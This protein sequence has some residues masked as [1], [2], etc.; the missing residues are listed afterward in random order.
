MYEEIDGVYIAP[1]K[2][3]NLSETKEESLKPINLSNHKTTE[4]LNQKAIEDA[5]RKVVALKNSSE[6]NIIGCIYKDPDL[7][8][9]LK[10]GYNRNNDIDTDGYFSNQSW[11]VYYQIAFDLYTKRNQT[12]F[13]QDNI[14]FYLE[15]HENLA[16]VY[17]NS[18]GYK[19]I[20]RLK[21]LVHLRDFDGYLSTLKKWYAVLKIA[22]EGFPIYNHLHEFADMTVEDVYN[23]YTAILNNAFQNVEE[24]VQ[25][26]NA[27]SMDG[28]EELIEE[29]DKGK[30][31]GKKFGDFKDTQN[32]YHDVCNILN[33]EIN[34][35]NLNG[36]IY[37]LGGCSGMG[38]SNLA[39]QLI[40]P[41]CLRENEPAV[42]IINE[43]DHQKF[44]QE[45]LTWTINNIIIPKHVKEDMIVPVYF[46]KRIFYVG[47]FTPVEKKWLKEAAMYLA[48][49]DEE[50][51]K[52]RGVNLI[53]VV[54]LERYSAK[55]AIKT[56]TK[57]AKLGGIKMFVLDT[58]KESYDIQRGVDTWKAMERD[59]VDFYNTVKPTA[60]NVGLFVTYQLGKQAIKTRYL[61]GSEVG[62]SKNIVDVMSV[63]M[64]FRKPWS[65]EMQGGKKE[66]KIRQAKKTNAEEDKEVSLQPGKNYGILFISKNRFGRQDSFQIV[67]ELDQGQNTL[68]EYGTTFC[69]VDFGT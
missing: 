25:S 38:K 27:F 22:D 20:E 44:R 1:E 36:N 10:T 63:N 45:V 17:D 30:Q 18:G 58:L 11:R 16:R 35:F 14:R 15:E 50:C 53:T 32:D 55:I 26:Y 43:E 6:A 24:E 49:K 66:L 23:M 65:D 12:V 56:I 40:V 29:T 51:K 41:I 31:V 59:L 8:L 57:Y 21:D 42:F 34:G 52:E 68:K 37:G 19:T 7:L 46:N 28:L 4:E 39:I 69:D 64:M 3:E 33:N 9:Q 13:T 47:G 62:Q 60:L 5:K 67:F 61:T 48:Q 2:T 54:P